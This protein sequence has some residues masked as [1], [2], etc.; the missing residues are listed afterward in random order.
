[1][2]AKLSRQYLGASTANGLQL[3]HEVLP[4]GDI[5]NS[6]VVYDPI[7]DTLWYPEANQ[8]NNNVIE[9]WNQ[10]SAQNNK[11]PNV[12]VNFPFGEGTG[13]FDPTHHLLFVAT[14]KGPLVSV[15]ANPETMTSS[16]IPGA[17]ITMVIDDGPSAQI[18]RAACR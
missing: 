2:N 11:N 13:A 17:V 15:Y 12:T 4:T 3:A 16:A 10:A 18:G 8:T 1:D 6:D 14:T 9:M 5:T 7:S